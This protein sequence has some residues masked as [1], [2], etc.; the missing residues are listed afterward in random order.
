MRVCAFSF[1]LYFCL[2]ICVFLSFFFIF[3]MGVRSGNYV[4]ATHTTPKEKKKKGRERTEERHQPSDPV[5]IVVDLVAVCLFSLN[6]RRTFLFGMSW[7]LTR[8]EVWW[9]EFPCSRRANKQQTGNI[10][11]F[12]IN[13]YEWRWYINV[14]WM[15]SLFF[16]FFSHRKRASKAQK[17]VR[18]K[19]KKVIFRF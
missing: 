3:L 8:S 2:P 7:L 4:I 15:P 10:V 12:T 13:K 17:N 14:A 16:F 5:V 18:R 19:R 11:L 9:P 1:S 6:V